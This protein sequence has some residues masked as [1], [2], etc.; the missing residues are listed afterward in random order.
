MCSDTPE[1]ELTESRVRRFVMESITRTL[2]MGEDPVNQAQWSEVHP[3]WHGPCLH[4]GMSD[5]E[6]TE[7]IMCT[8]EM[9]QA[10]MMFR[11]E[12]AQNPNEENEISGWIMDEEEVESTDVSQLLLDL[13]P[14]EG[15]WQ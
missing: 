3:G 9:E 13:I 1:Q 15:D 4:E 5:E 10:I 6:L 7:W 2:D 14:L 12:T 11:G 8:E